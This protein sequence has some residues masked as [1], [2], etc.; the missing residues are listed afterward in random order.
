MSLEK[1]LGKIWVE[2]TLMAEAL[3]EDPLSCHTQSVLWTEEGV[4]LS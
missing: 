4:S 3:G 1:L 2:E